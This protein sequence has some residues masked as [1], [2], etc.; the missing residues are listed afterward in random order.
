[1]TLTDS[2]GTLEKALERN[3]LIDEHERLLPLLDLTLGEVHGCPSSPNETRIPRRW[4]CSRRVCPSRD[5]IE[6]RANLEG[7]LPT[8]ALSI[9][10]V[11]S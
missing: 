5:R 8:C 2:V 3:L 7:E 11:G 4:K 6:A 9:Y 10:T 1:M